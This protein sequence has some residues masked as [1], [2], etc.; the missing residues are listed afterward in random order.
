[1]NVPSLLYDIAM[2]S[3]IVVVIFFFSK[4]RDHDHDN[5]LRILGM[6]FVFNYLAKVV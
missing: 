1:M 3:G 6:D 5:F 4:R 2:T